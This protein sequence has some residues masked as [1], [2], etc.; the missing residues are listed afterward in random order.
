M[1]MKKFHPA[2]TCQL[3]KPEDKVYHRTFFKLNIH[4]SSLYNST[5]VKNGHNCFSN[6]TEMIEKQTLSKSYLARK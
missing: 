5:I 1:L 2:C 6:G 3:S 4:L